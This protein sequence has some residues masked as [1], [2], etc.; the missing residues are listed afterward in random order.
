[1]AAPTGK[2]VLRRRFKWPGAPD[3]EAYGEGFCAG[4]EFLVITPD[5][6]SLTVEDLGLEAAWPTPNEP[7]K[8]GM[9]TDDDPSTS[10]NAGIPAKHQ[11]HCARCF[12][13]SRDG[14]K[15][16]FQCLGSFIQ[17]SW[18]VHEGEE[19]PPSPWVRP[20]SEDA[21][22]EVAETLPPK[23]KFPGPEAGPRQPPWPPPPLLPPGITM[24]PPPP[25]PVHPA[26][27]G[28]APAAATEVPPPE[29]FPQSN[30]RSFEECVKVVVSSFNTKRAKAMREFMAKM[31]EASRDFQ[32]EMSDLVYSEVDHVK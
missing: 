2:Y 32:N 30:K 19:D 1:M 7:E 8:M 12:L 5:G 22:S 6:R 18:C 28:A 9:W 20:D 23:S 29:E 14:Q 3:L 10:P 15:A 24:P 4:N 17:H 16:K 13:M 31:V 27:S 11:I 26:S 21:A 25:P